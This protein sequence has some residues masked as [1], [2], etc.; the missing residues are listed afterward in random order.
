[1]K[2]IQGHSIQVRLDDSFSLRKTRKSYHNTLFK[3]LTIKTKPNQTKPN[4]NKTGPQPVLKPGQAHFDQQVAN[5]V[6]NYTYFAAEPCKLYQVI[7]NSTKGDPDLTIYLATSGSI[8]QVTISERYGPEN[9]AVCPASMNGKLGTLII[10]VLS[11]Q[12]TS[13]AFGVGLN[14][15]LVVNPLGR[16]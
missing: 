6:R 2:G 3:S 9:F 13:A 1:M 12:S 4:Q 7:A 8:T 15:T 11:F 16:T 10:Q 14:L 5:S